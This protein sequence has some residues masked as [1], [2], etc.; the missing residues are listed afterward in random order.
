MNL[1]LLG[2]LLAW[3]GSLHAGAHQVYRGIEEDL[4]IEVEKQPVPFNHRR[5]AGVGLGCVDCHVT[6]ETKA[7]ASLPN[8]DLCLAC[9]GGDESS[10]E[11]IQELKRLQQAGKKIRW[12]RVYEVPDFVF[13]NHANHLKAQMTCETCHGPVQEREVL[14]KE[15]CTSMT[16]CMN[17]HAARIVPNHCSF[18]HSLGH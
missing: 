12:V 11:E 18:S 13:F 5:H 16:T 15:V 14:A 10:S 17:C 9:H 1:L 4:P 6:V 2:L 7:W 8:L 3:T